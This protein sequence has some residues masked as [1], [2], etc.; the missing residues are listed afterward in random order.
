[1]VKR[2]K[3]P[4]S[5][6]KAVLGSPLLVAML[7]MAVVVFGLSLIGYARRGGFW[8]P[9]VEARVFDETGRRADGEGRDSQGRRLFPLQGEVFGEVERLRE[10]AALSLAATL[11]AANRVMLGRPVGTVQELLAAVS[12]DRALPPGLVL[13]GD[14][15]RVTSE[16]GE[17]YVRYRPSPLGVEVVS[18]GTGKMP[19][20]S[21]L[22]RLPDEDASADGLTYYVF[23]KAE[24]V[25]VPGGFVPLAEVIGAGWLP[26]RFRVN[27]VSAEDMAKARQ[28]MDEGRGR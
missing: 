22:I 13:E 6:R 15:T 16:V 28:W 20:R 2:E 25:K 11:C 10:G 26:E 1:M 7:A 4:V 23:S 24:D 12:A 19:G 17:Y 21:F 18:L 9:K 8:S 3:Q 27:Q 14:G 5:I